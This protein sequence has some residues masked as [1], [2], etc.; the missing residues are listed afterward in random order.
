MDE[1]LKPSPFQF[2]I[3]PPENS[4][5]IPYPIVFVSEE[6][7]VYELEEGDRRYMEEPF[8]PGDGARPYVKSRYDEKNGWGNLRGF[9]RR[10][11]LPKGIEVAPAPTH[12]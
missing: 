7:K 11:D 6:G 10:S 5:D 1:P 12:D 8:H 4:N 2:A 9:L 3:V